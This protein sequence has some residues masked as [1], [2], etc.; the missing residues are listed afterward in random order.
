MDPPTAFRN[1]PRKRA[2]DNM[3]DFIDDMFGGIHDDMNA[4]GNPRMMETRIKGGGDEQ[5][6]VI[7]RLDVF[8]FVNQT[9][10]IKLFLNKF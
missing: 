5:K 7:D 4:F 8:C 3:E 1:E 6:Q 2:S 9:I 10:L